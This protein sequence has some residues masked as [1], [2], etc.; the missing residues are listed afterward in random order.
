VRVGGIAEL[1]DIKR[2]TVTITFAHPAP[3]AAFE[4]VPGVDAVEALDDGLTLRIAVTGE[5]DGVVKAAA[6]YPVATL[7]THEPSLEEIFLRYY[8]EADDGAA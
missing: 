7:A 4:A 5:L 1:K 8:R 3:A 6:Q 2:H